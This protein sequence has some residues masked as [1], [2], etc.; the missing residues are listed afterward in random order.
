MTRAEARPQWWSLTATRAAV[1]LV[2]RG[3]ARDRWQ[4]ELVAELHGLSRVE[5]ARHTIGVVTRAP[6]LRAAVTARDRVALPGEDIVRIPVSCKLHLHRWHTVS[7]EDGSG[8]FRQCRRCGKED[9]NDGSANW[10]AGGA[11]G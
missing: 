7:A 10:F 8:R 2:P 1:R 4:Q 11:M 9:T 3:G 6:A 5:Q